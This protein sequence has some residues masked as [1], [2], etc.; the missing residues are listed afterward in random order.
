MLIA[1]IQ[2]ISSELSRADQRVGASMYERYTE[3]VKDLDAL[4]IEVDKVAPVR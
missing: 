1:Q 4:K 2:N 3:V